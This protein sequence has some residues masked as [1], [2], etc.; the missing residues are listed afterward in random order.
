MW[1]VPRYTREQVRRRRR[2]AALILAAL[3]LVVVGSCTAGMVRVIGGS[4]AESQAAEITATPERTRRAD[5]SAVDVPA[6]PRDAAALSQLPAGE[7][8]ADGEALGIDVSAHQGAIDWEQIRGSG[9]SFAYIKATEGTGHVDE[10]FVANWQGADQAGLARGAYHYFTLCSGGEEQAIDFLNAVPPSDDHLPPVIDLELD[11]SCEAAPDRATVDREV[12]TFVEAV[13]KA[14]GRR[15]VVYSS[16]DWR[17]TYGLPEETTRPQWH[18]DVDERPDTDWDI[19]QVRFD[20]RLPGI[21]HDVDLD[22]MKVDDLR[23][24]SAL[25]A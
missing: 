24:A 21:N 17:N 2:V 1:H 25:D 15:V 14:W 19:W 5:P 9:V 6:T 4:A 11:G 7:S 20:A 3:L 22:V 16:W 12:S 18:S 8:L 10:R 23:E 13:E